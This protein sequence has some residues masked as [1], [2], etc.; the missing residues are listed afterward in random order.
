MKKIPGRE[1]LKKFQIPKL[2]N[3]IY[4]LG[5]LSNNSKKFLQK[6]FKLNVIHNQNFHL[7]I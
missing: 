3:Q 7:E 5:N 4:V 2:I 1:L 6:K